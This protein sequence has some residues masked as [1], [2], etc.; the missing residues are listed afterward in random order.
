MYPKMNRMR[1]RVLK[2]PNPGPQILGFPSSTC[3]GNARLIWHLY[4]ARYNVKSCV[5]ERE[6]LLQYRLTETF[7]YMTSGTA[8]AE[9]GKSFNVSPTRL[10]IGRFPTKQIQRHT[11]VPVTGRN[12]RILRRTKV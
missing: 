10:P 8:V 2:M 12:M 7:A 4:L 6:S 5:G 11:N 9:P 1:E 3:K